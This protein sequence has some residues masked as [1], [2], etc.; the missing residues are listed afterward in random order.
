[1]IYASGVK[2]LLCNPRYQGHSYPMETKRGDVAAAEAKAAHTASGTVYSSGQYHFHVRR[3]AK[4]HV[5]LCRLSD[6]P[7]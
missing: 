7:C 2:D 4:A 6:A 3:P 5:Q 1:M